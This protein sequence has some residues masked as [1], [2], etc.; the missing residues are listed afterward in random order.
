MAVKKS[1]FAIAVASEITMSCLFVTVLM[2]RGST[3]GIASE[4]DMFCLFV[5]GMMSMGF[6]RKLAEIS[7]SAQALNCSCLNG[8]QPT[9]HSPVKSSH[10]QL[11]P[12]I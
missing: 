4:I 8:L 9:Q 5:T 1:L 6:L 3:I 12:V 7:I 10:P 2:S 11:F